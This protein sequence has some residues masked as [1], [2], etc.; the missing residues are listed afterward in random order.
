VEGFPGIEREVNGVV[1]WVPHL[2][3][4][5]LTSPLHFE[6]GRRMVAGREVTS[7]YF[8]S[9][10]EGL[11]VAEHVG[12]EPFA[13]PA[14]EGVVAGREHVGEEKVPPLA[15]RAMEGVEEHVGDEIDHSVRV[16]SDGRGGGR[17]RACG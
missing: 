3:A 16:S 10:K 12:D 13:F 9:D 2:L 5:K 4:S 6:W 1:D 11:R 15:F 7:A 14:T 17:H 8:L